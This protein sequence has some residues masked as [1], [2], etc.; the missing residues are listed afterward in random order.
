MVG[1]KVTTSNSYYLAIYCGAEIK[2]LDTFLQEYDLNYY[3]NRNN[4]TFRT[5]IIWFS[6]KTDN[7]VTYKYDLPFRYVDGNN[8]GNVY[9]TFSSYIYDY[10]YKG[11]IILIMIMATIIEIIYEKSKRS[12]LKDKPNIMILIYGYMFSSI[13]LAFYSNKFYEQN[14]NIMFIYAILSWFIFNNTLTK[15]KFKK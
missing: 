15:I 7:P 3:T 1:R 10:G 6:Q 12:I 13:I 14:D 5:F 4:M 11:M 8:L 2:N 9:T